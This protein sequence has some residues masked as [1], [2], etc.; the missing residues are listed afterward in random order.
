QDRRQ[1]VF[2]SS[3]SGDYKLYVTNL[4]GSAQTMLR[5]PF[6]N[7]ARVLP[8]PNGRRLAF[9]K[10]GTHLALIDPDGA[11]ER[12]LTCQRAKGVFDFAWSP[13]STRLVFSSKPP[14]SQR[15][16]LFV[17]RANGTDLQ[18]VTFTPDQ[19]HSRADWSP[20]GSTI[21]FRAVSETAGTA[22]YTVKPDGSQL[23]RIV[24]LQGV[25]NDPAW[26]PDSRYLTFALSKPG[27]NTDI[28]RVNADGTNLQQLTAHQGDNYDT[29]WLHVP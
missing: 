21:A 16:Q 24:Q 26:S 1:V 6:G 27:E 10:D 2:G 11:H 12:C 9:L 4:D 7:N 23:T 3:F 29:A 13:D 20:D 22:I 19:S 8:A 28:Y 18:R 14:D 25:P 15:N 17:V 5:T